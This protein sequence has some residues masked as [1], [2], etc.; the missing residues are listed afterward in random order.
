MKC[1]IPGFYKSWMK[2]L[3]GRLAKQYIKHITQNWSKEPFAKGAYA[4]DF[5]APKTIAKLQEPIDNRLYFAGDAY[6]DGTD[7]G[8]VHN[9]I[10]SARQCVEMILE[11]KQ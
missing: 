9:A 2:Y 5:T 6:T 3:K 10:S 8:N 11:E 1:S 7:W 4:S